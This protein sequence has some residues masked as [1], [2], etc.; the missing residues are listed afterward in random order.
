MLYPTRSACSAERGAYMRRN[1]RSRFLFMSIFLLLA[2]LCFVPCAAEE[3]KRGS[4]GDEVKQLQQ[5]LID[6][7]FLHD[8]ADGIFGKKTQAAVMDYQLY[9]GA[10]ESGVADEGLINDLTLLWQMAMGIEAESGAPIDDEGY[11]P[12]CSFTTDGSWHA[13]YCARHIG[14]YPAAIQLAGSNPPKE[15]ERLLAE[16]VSSFWYESICMMYA[17][18]AYRLGHAEGNAADEQYDIFLAELDENTAMWNGQSV[19]GSNEAALERMMWLDG[20][21]V[22][23]CFD[24]YGAEKNP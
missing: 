13:E 23:L 7:G 15:L 9:C 6:T 17:D 11:P 21:G 24:L 5:M 18:W 4:R 8:A 2:A 1:E 3:L 16:R 14:Q 19:P 12:S 20:V 10:E 22:N